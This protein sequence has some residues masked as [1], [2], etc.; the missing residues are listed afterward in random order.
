MTRG[1]TAWQS[2]KGEVCHAQRRPDV[3][4]ADSSQSR[5]ETTDPLLGIPWARGKGSGFLTQQTT[6][7]QEQTLEGMNT[8]YIQECPCYIYDLSSAIS[9]FAHD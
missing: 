5:D 1:Q 6:E 2:V 4:N 9:L 3:E 8:Y 7:K